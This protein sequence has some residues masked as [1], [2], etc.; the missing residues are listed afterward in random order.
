MYQNHAN[1]SQGN[2]NTQ[3]TLEFRDNVLD[4]ILTCDTVYQG[5]ENSNKCCSKTLYQCTDLEY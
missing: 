5:E 2:T 3:K 1:K 4:V